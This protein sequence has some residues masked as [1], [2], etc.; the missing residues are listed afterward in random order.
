MKS[1]AYIV[2]LHHALPEPP[3]VLSR[4]CFIMSLI[5]LAELSAFR[6]GLVGEL[7]LLFSCSFSSFV[8][9]LRKAICQ[10]NL[11][12]NWRWTYYLWL[13][14]AKDNAD[15]ELRRDT[16]SHNST[17]LLYRSDILSGASSVPHPRCWNLI[18]N[19]QY[20][21]YALSNSRFTLYCPAFFL[22]STTSLYHGSLVLF[23][24]LISLLFSGGFSGFSPGLCVYRPSEYSYWENGRYFFLYSVLN[25]M[26]FAGFSSSVPAF[27][28]G[29]SSLTVTNVHGA[30]R[31]LHQYLYHLFYK[32]RYCLCRYLIPSF[33]GF[34]S[35]TKWSATQATNP[36]NHNIIYEP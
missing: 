19:I 15:N 33:V 17:C 29:S 36:G 8:Y 5:H 24:N 1:N 4:W 21:I 35:P 3:V 32:T 10:Q 30:Y 9:D 26:L 28:R 12:V 7:R 6:K 20:R 16:W 27:T 25:T 23:I 18:S 22:S 2:G 31:F 34:K 11:R 14:E 13:V